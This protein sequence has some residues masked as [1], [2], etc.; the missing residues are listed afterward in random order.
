MICFELSRQ[1]C[2]MEFK[3][4]ERGGESGLSREIR[5][6]RRKLSNQARYQQEQRWFPYPFTV[7]INTGFSAVGKA[8]PMTPSGDGIG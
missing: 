8:E 2:C 6:S 4:K 7:K 5:R 3:T 1:S